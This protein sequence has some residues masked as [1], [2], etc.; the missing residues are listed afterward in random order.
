MGNCASN[1]RA[2]K[3]TRSLSMQISSPNLLFAD[4]TISETPK[5]GM[6]RRSSVVGMSRR[7]SVVMRKLTSI[8]KKNSD[9]ADVPSAIVID[10]PPNLKEMETIRKALKNHYLFSS[11][12]E[13]SLKVFI[14]QMKYYT[15]SKPGETIFYQGEIGNNFFVVTSGK[16]EVIINGKHKRIISKGCCVG[17]IALMLNSTRT[18]TVKTIERTSMWGIDRE[19]FKAAMLSIYNEKYNENKKFL[20]SIQIFKY[21]E[22]EQKEALLNESVPLMYADGEKIICEGDE[23]ILFYIITGGKV[24]CSKGCVNIRLMGKGEFFGDQA[25]LYDTKRTAMV[26]ADGVAKLLAI[27]RDKL[28]RIFGDKLQSIAYRNSQKFAIEKNPVLRNL[29][30]N[31]IEKLIDIGEIK[32]YDEGNVVIGSEIDK[33]SKMWIL[34]DGKLV[35]EQNKE[36]EI[37]YQTVI[38]AEDIMNPRDEKYSTVWKAGVKVIVA[39]FSIRDIENVLGSSLI[40]ALEKNQVATVL[41]KVQLFRDLS[42]EKLRHLSSLLKIEEF[43]G[44]ECIF[45][46]GDPGDKFYVI[47][48]G[49]VQVLKNNIVMRTLNQ[50]EYFGERAI[51]LN[52]KRGATIVTV[53]KTI[54]W[55]LNQ[56]DF[57]ELVNKALH[58]QLMRHIDLRND[59]ITLDDLSIVSYICQ[60]LYYNFYLVVHKK[61]KILY[62]LKT[63]SRKQINNYRLHDNLIMERKIMMILDHAFMINLV[64]TM[65]DQARIY[66]LLE[67][68]QGQDFY[69]VLKRLKKLSNSTTKFYACCFLM[70]LEY[71]H[72]NKIIYR[73]LNPDNI[74]IDEK[75]YPKLVDFGSSTIL[76]GRT[77]TI[78][79]SPHYMAPEV[80]LGKGYNQYCDYWSLG[81]MIFQIAFGNLPFGEESNDPT[82]IYEIV[83]KDPIIFP[84]STPPHFEKI[85]NF[86][87]KL[88]NKS[89]PAARGNID[90]LKSHHWVSSTDWDALLR[91]SILPPYIPPHENWTEEI[92]NALRS[93][94][95]I[96]NGL[97]SHESMERALTTGDIFGKSMISKDWDYDF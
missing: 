29:K 20:E 18:A 93:K 77:Y 13:E 82:E 76:Y 12:S 10:R 73:D 6:S 1:C 35:S 44:N 86:I 97:L 62:V 26:V 34:L 46:Q 61:R 80:I 11:L 22:P 17:E 79:G 52:E 94:E 39:E 32:I 74:I 30:K 45:H 83:L 28:V 88:L 42:H 54:C 14:P 3:N 87:E 48:R 69:S 21:L 90:V 71:L 31:Q 33:G 40:D 27:T 41:R 85:K 2:K 78:I 4:N 8:N 24:M 68:I 7:S 64:K 55:T 53:G 84:S 70:M 89:T 5:S 38:G 16:L 51:V 57:L 37:P 65:K 36:D 43:E 56:T 23:G 15:I 19:Q 63:I 67:Y 72:E 25:L 92:N 47:K 59:F 95:D 81:V 9:E 49:Q 91:K 66:F 96:L 50:F 75:G 58:K 60:D